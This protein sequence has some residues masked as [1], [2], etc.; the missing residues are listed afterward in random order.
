MK[1]GIITIH[2]SP[3]YGA[4][5][6]SFALY[7]FINSLG[8]DCE[9]IDL[10]RPTHSDYIQSLEYVEYRKP[11]GSL[12]QKLKKLIKRLIRGKSSSVAK[13]LTDEAAVK[14]EKFNSPMNCSIPYLSIDQLY[15]NPPLYD[16]YVTGSDQLWNPTMK[17]CIEPYFLTFAPKGARKISY[18]TSVAVSSLL[19]NEERDYCQW[20]KDYESISVREQSA[21]E[22][23]SRL[24]GKEVTQV[25][26]PTF[27][28]SYDEWK[29]Y[30]SDIDIHKPYILLFTLGYRKELADYA[31]K[32]SNESG[33]KMVY[34]CLSHPY[35][36]VSYTIERN[37]GPSE[38][39][40]YIANAE[41]VITDSFHGT[42]FCMH[43]HTKN[44]F[45]YISNKKRGS[46]ITDMLAKFN[47]SE[48]LLG[49]SLDKSYNQLCSY[50]IC[51]QQLKDAMSEERKRCA[52][53]LKHA[54]NKSLTI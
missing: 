19:P 16:V 48:H 51:H 33:V 27:L 13:P 54:I 31:H 9:I 34:L 30:S 42:A 2:K 28:L 4:S 21:V 41:M 43:M 39:L 46:R 50:T 37:S 10:H 11:Q 35:I 52:D 26:D 47:L 49:D 32:L 6:Q 18:A 29:R 17:F 15:A 38:F 40:T 36:N 22:L 44:F 8:Y 53:F 20:L 24:S 14:F 45:T 23:I 25:S 3:N 12:L 5:L 7:S 1:I